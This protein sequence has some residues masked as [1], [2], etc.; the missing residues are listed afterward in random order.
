[1]QRPYELGRAHLDLGHV[2]E[3]LGRKDEAERNFD[4][5]KKVY[6]KLEIPRK[7]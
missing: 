4:V 5:A 2:L 6:E 3:K 7:F 1:M